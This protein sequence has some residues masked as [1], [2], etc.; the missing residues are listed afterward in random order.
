MAIKEQDFTKGNILPS[1]I[2]FSIPCIIMNLIQSLFILTDLFIVGHWSEHGESIAA[3]TIA[4][5]PMWLHMI[6]LMGLSGAVN[7]LIGRAFGAK[8]LDKMDDIVGS[9]MTLFASAGLFFTIELFVLAQVYLVLLKT[10]DEVMSLAV[11]YLKISALGFLPIAA[12]NLLGAVLRGVG[13]STTP[14]LYISVGLFINVVFDILFVI[15]LNM[16]S[17]GAAIATVISQFIGCT[18]AIFYLRIKQ[19][20]FRFELKD[21]GFRKET[22]KNIFLLALP[23][24]MQ[25]IFVEISF[26]I[27]MIIVNMMGATASAGYGIVL[28]MWS[29]TALPAYSFGIVLE[30][31]A[32]QNIGAI[33]LKRAKN[34]LYWC[35]LLSAIPCF[36]YVAFI[37]VFPDFVMSVFTNKQDIIKAGSDF[38]LSSS[39]EITFLP[40]EFCLT[41]FFVACGKP[42]FA[43]ISTVLSHFVIKLPLAYIFV[44]VLNGGMYM[45]GWS[46]TIPAATTVALYFIYFASGRWVKIKKV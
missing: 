28:K 8:E 6:F 42:V 40:F 16:G 21:F 38:L 9:S 30:A 32:S 7:V 33:R 35:F 1:L 11:S 39:W 27:I 3:I 24:S 23:I 37:Q 41:S 34:A 26:M 15:V 18:F 14:L 36:I 45:L 25:E 46:F 19:F 4:A 31:V 20:L 10:P 5:S 44:F 2:K 12:F 17:T 43:M 13:N 29:F 22:V